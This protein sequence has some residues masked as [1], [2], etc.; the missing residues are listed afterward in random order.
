MTTL[1]RR[2]MSRESNKEIMTRSHLSRIS[3][4]HTERLLSSNIEKFGYTYRESTRTRTLTV[5][6]SSQ[7]W[8]PSPTG[9]A[10]RIASPHVHE[11]SQSHGLPSSGYPYRQVRLQVVLN[12]YRNISLGQFK[13]HPVSPIAS[14]VVC[15]ISMISPY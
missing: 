8:L 15:L 4:K 14:N 12:T 1:F 9:S 10:T 3:S 11:L 13:R 7:L 6:R 5:S 2:C